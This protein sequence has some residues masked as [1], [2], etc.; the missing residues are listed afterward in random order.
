MKQPKTKSPFPTSGYFGP[1]YF[2]N[3]REETD[4]LR[5]N[6]ESNQS[7]T[8]VSIRRM[9]KTGLIKHIQ[10][11]LSDK[12]IC[13]YA[14]ILPTENSVELTNSLSN[15]IINAVPAKTKLHSRAWKLIQSLRPVVSYDTLT[16]MP[17]VSFNLQPNETKAHIGSLLEFL[18]KQEKPVLFAIDE[19]QQILNYPEKRV[20]AW[21]R[22]LI[23]QLKNVTFIFSGSQQHLMNDLFS[24]PERPFFRS[25]SF[26]SLNEIDFS[27]YQNFILQKF[28][29][30]QKKISSEIISEIL[31]WTNVHTY[32]VQLLCNRVYVNSGKKIT[33]ETW[34][35]EA[36]RILNEQEYI[37]YNYRE[38]L[39]KQQWN[40][41]K[42]VAAENK[43]FAPTSKKFINDHNLGSPA[44]VRRSLEALHTKELVYRNYDSEGNL[45]YSIYDVL[46]KNWI[47]KNS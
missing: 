34:K 46:F 3:R 17:N 1:E 9:G 14:D 42:A 15:A 2:C 25:T 45:Y 28:T 36:V 38:L 39:T 21:L 11:Q 32:Y 5:K 41:L 18:E 47:Q 20:D 8:L 27:E 37:F 4:I 13:I 35:Q 10:N 7:T 22:T 6:I 16:G 29:E 31:T 40:L 24:N 19:F 44:T 23:Q 43:V 26:L 33:S 30:R 12:V